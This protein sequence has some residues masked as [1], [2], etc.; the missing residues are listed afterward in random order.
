MDIGSGGGGGAAAVG[1]VGAMGAVAAVFTMMQ[2]L[3]LLLAVGRLVR[4]LGDSVRK[5]C[6][7]AMAKFL[8]GWKGALMIPVIAAFV[9]WF[10]N[11]LAVKMIFYPVSFMGLDIHTYVGQVRAT[12]GS[13]CDTA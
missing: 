11:W 7:R 12:G 4:P 3:A 9:G 6:K 5:H 10:T 2:R 13:A 8:A 1:A